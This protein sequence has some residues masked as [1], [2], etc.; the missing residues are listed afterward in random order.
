[1]RASVDIPKRDNIHRYS[2]VT[3][4]L[5]SCKYFVSFAVVCD[6]KNEFLWRKSPI[7]Q[8]RM[9]IFRVTSWTFDVI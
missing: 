3:V 5:Y 9:A 2:A 8:K 6:H 4:L 7:L 1:M